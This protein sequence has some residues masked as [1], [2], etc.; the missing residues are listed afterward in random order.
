MREEKLITKKFYDRNA[1]D[2]VIKRSNLNYCLEEFKEF[3]ELIPSG[4][5]LDIGC[6]T[7][8]DASLFQ[9][10]GYDYVGIDISSGM[11][12][13]A[14]KLFPEAEFKEMDLS[15]LEFPNESF[16]GIW[17]FAAYLHLP[18]DEIN[19]AIEEANRVLK[20][21]G[22]GFISIKKG[23]FEK[24]LGDDEKKRYWSF[25]GKNQFAQIL[26]DN[27]FEIVKVWEDKRDYNPPEDVTV[28]LCY[29]I[30]KVR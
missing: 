11:I 22:I 29:F 12:A 10:N 4:R 19:K 23:S 21:G 5:V 28:F 2:W 16:D 27:G 24:Y 1:P 9:P 15:K 20:L 26:K 8:R 7:G 18:K 17:S 6:G 30:R 14:R 25:W 13:E 3:Q